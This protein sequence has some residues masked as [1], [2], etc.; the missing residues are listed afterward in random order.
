MQERDSLAEK[1]REAEGKAHASTPQ[2]AQNGAADAD[3]AEMLARLQEALQD[4]FES[5]DRAEAALLANVQAQ[6]GRGDTE[7]GAPLSNG[8]EPV[9]RSGR[10]HADGAESALAGREDASHQQVR[11]HCSGIAGLWYN[12][13]LPCATR[14][15]FPISLV[16][17]IHHIGIEAAVWKLSY[18]RAWGDSHGTRQ[19]WSSGCRADAKLG[20]TLRTAQLLR[21]QQTYACCTLCNARSCVCRRQA[22]CTPGSRQRRLRAQQCSGCLL[23]TT[24]LR[25]MSSG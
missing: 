2:G 21:V 17:V 4:A 13:Q 22:T 1:L 16:K 18:W 11:T 10:G 23:T 7:R 8:G 6:A 20:S 12:I 19:T 5:R 14:G 9:E 25:W 15:V 3:S 24:V